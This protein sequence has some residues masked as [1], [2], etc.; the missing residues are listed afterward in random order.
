MQH[1]KRGLKIEVIEMIC[2]YEGLFPDDQNSFQLHQI[3]DLV[4]SIQ[5]HDSMLYAWSFVENC[6]E[7]TVENCQEKQRKTPA[8][9]SGITE[10]GIRDNI[11]N[12]GRY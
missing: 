8:G 11:P 7:D 3:M 9:W 4:C 5:L 1:V 2:L 12:T 6:Q 10:F